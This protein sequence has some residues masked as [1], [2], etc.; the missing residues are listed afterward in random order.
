MLGTN[1]ITSTSGSD[2]VQATI[3]VTYRKTG[4]YYTK[5]ATGN[6][7]TAA[8]GK[9]AVESGGYLTAISSYH[10]AGF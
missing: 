4:N 8:Q 10:K 9:Y 2:Y 1:G 7:K 5:S 3:K 6:G